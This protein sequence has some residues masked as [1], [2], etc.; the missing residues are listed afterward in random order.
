MFIFLQIIITLLAAAT[1]FGA[2]WT[3]CGKLR[4][5]IHRTRGTTTVHT[6]LSVREGADGLEQTIEGLMWLMKNGTIEG[7]ILIADCGMNEEGR[8][9]ARLAVKKY[10]TIAICKAEDVK[11]WIVEKA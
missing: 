11:Q 3:L 2:F 9:L 10:G 1:L 4:T 6:I 7:Q 5:P 8:E